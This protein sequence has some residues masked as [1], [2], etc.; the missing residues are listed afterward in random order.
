M[1]IL[2][3]GGSG[4]IGSELVR[5]FLQKNFNVINIDNL[6]QGSVNESLEA[7]LKYKNYK[8]NNFSI[9]NEK[10]IYNTIKN[11][12]PNYIF[13]LAA[14]S[15]VDNSI[16]NPIKT[17]QTNVIGTLNLVNCTNLLIKNKI[18]DINKFKF[19]HVS[20]D[21]VY[22]SLKINENSFTEKNIYS[23]NSPYSASKAGS[24]YIIKSFFK[25]FKFPGIITHCVN[26]FG[27]WQ[28][29]EKL[30]PVVIY[31]CLNGEKIPVYGNGKN[32]REW[33]Y[34]KDHINALEL[35][36]RKGKIGET[37]NIGSGYR[38]SNLDLVIKICNFMNDLLSSKIDFKKLISFVGDRPG[39]DFK[40][41]I[42]SNKIKNTLKFKNKYKFNESLRNTVKWYIDN[43]NWTKKKYK[44]IEK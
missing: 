16:N 30:I 12:K 39:H 38:I 11:E 17:F 10:K 13:N 8:F 3:T 29:P 19:I 31:K 7:F 22:G 2:I 18:L 37:Y 35:I 24:D 9:N 28:F 15:H 27:P 44:S 36:S 33:I 6:S 25:T 4:F 41:S 14:E 32:I 23:P 21:E 26:N 34:V 40:Y 5:Y 1:K 42:N 20:T 43:N